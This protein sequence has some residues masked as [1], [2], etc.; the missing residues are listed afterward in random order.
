MD[1][2][3]SIEQIIS[4][5]HYSERFVLMIKCSEASTAVVM[6]T[7]LYYQPKGLVK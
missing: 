2:N 1:E 7:D 6:R 4:A 5:N 3:S